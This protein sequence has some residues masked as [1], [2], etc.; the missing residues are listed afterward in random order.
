MKDYLMGDV[1]AKGNLL[2]LH[3]YEEGGA[4]I[5]MRKEENKECMDK[6]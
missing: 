6:S 5:L 2:P 1:Y 3:Y 4:V